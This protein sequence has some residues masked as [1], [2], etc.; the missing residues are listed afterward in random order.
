[1]I[2]FASTVIYYLDDPCS[3]GGGRRAVNEPGGD[4]PAA[5]HGQEGRCQEE[6]RPDL[7][8]DPQRS[9]QEEDCQ[10][11]CVVYS[12]KRNCSA[13]GLCRGGKGSHGGG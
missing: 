13:L 7:R 10:C 6:L 1:M 9:R 5:G 12:L 3:L 4:L 2:M 11:H 8:G